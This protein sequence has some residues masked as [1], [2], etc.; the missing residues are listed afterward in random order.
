MQPSK[1]DVGDDGKQYT[2][3]GLIGK[4]LSTIDWALIVYITLTK[5]CIVL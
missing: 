3:D 2:Y 4:K 5:F 1:I